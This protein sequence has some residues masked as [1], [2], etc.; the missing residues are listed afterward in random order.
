MV[1]EPSQRSVSQIDSARTRPFRP[2]LSRWIAE[3]DTPW[4]AITTF[5]APAVLVY[6]LFTAYPVLR[7]ISNS[8]FTVKPKGNG[9]FVGLKNYV[10]LFTVDPVFWKTVANTMIWATVG[11]IADVGIGLLLALR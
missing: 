7:T 9:T 8:F 3:S 1:T 6:A 2:R 11:P 5:L 4:P 10:E